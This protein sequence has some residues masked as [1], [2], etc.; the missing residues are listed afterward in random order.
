MRWVSNFGLKRMAAAQR[1]LA[2]RELASNQVKYNLLDRG[3][4]TNV[5]PYAQK[6]K[7]TII[8][9]SPLAQ[10]LLTG[11]YT[12]EDRPRSLIQK[13]NSRFSSRNLTRLTHLAW[14]MAQIAKAHDKTPSQVA[15]NWLIRNENVI[16]IPGVKGPQH[17]IDN[18]GAADWRL[19]E[20]E[21]ERL[22]T[23]ARVQFDRISGIPSAV[24]ALM[25]T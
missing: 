23:A 4:E 11:R 20:D 25:R 15:L 17:V 21:V 22:E 8:A 24:R 19:T 10:S 9:Y 14:T 16:A 7:V 12:P 2:P 1:S 6:E 5:L 3:I 18:A 13:I